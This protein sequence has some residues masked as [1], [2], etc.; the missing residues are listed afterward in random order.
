MS[1]PRSQ[2]PRRRNVLGLLFWS[3]KQLVGLYRWSESARCQ[4]AGDDDIDSSATHTPQKEE[5]HR[6]PRPSCDAVIGDTLPG[7]TRVCHLES[8]VPKVN[9]NIDMEVCVERRG[10]KRN[11]TAKN[12]PLAHPIINL[13]PG[14]EVHNA[15]DRA[16]QAR[17]LDL[18]KLEMRKTK[19]VFD[20]LMFVLEPRNVH[21][22]QPI[23]S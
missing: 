17:E 18:K 5:K 16:V 6:G 11:R 4:A 21:S 14:D 13:E 23:T 9:S 19:T 1:Q 2:R 10:R 3:V 7:R 12:A 22:N 20:E 15:F 8:V